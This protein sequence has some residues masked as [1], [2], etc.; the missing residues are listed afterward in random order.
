MFKETRGHREASWETVGCPGAKTVFSP[1]PII[2]FFIHFSGVSDVPWNK[3]L[4]NLYHLGVS[5]IKFIGIFCLQNLELFQLQE[6]Q[7][8]P[9]VLLD[10]RAPDLDAVFHIVMVSDNPYFHVFLSLGS[11]YLLFKFIGIFS[12][13]P[14]LVHP[15]LFYIPTV[16][17][18]TYCV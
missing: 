2:I 9:P 17:L 5:Q 16:T 18:S 6:S 13:C 14:A 12:S 10:L 15:L 8:H 11:F 4:Q 7:P 3:F 1:T